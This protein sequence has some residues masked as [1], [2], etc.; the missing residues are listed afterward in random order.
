MWKP[1]SRGAM[2]VVVQ[3]PCLVFLAALVLP[4]VFS[5][6]G[7][8]QLELNDQQGWSVKSSYSSRAYDAYIVA[9]AEIEAANSEAA[10][11][12]TRTEASSNY[13]DLYWVSSRS[14]ADFLN[15]PEDLYYI[16]A[17][18]EEVI[19]QDAIQ[20]VCLLSNSTGQCVGAYSATSFLPELQ[21]DYD[22]NTFASDLLSDI[23]DTSF[24]VS[25]AFDIT[26]TDPS[27]VVMP[28]LR[29]RLQFGLPLE[30]YDSAQDRASEQSDIIQEAIQNVAIDYL[31]PLRTQNDAL[32]LYF[33]FS[34]ITNYYVDTT[35]VSD[36]VYAGAAGAFV[37]TM[38]C[39]H[40]RSVFLGFTSLLQIL[41]SFPTAYFAYR[42]IVG[43]EHFG[44]L[45][46]LAIFLV[47]GIGTDDIFIFWDAFRQSAVVFAAKADSPDVLVD[48]LDW[49]FR[50]AAGAMLVTSLTTFV[51]FFVTALSPIP[52][53]KDFGM[54]AALLIV[55]NFFMVITIFPCLVIIHM[56]YIKPIPR[57]GLV[58]TF[59]RDRWIPL[60]WRARWPIL[61]VG[62]A[63]M[64]SFGSLASRFT[65]GTKRIED[66]FDAD[67]PLTIV[68]ALKIEEFV[69]SSNAF[70]TATVTLGLELIDR[71]GTSP[72]DPSDYGTLSYSEGFAPFQTDAQQALFD[73]CSD[74]GDEN[75][76]N[77]PDYVR[78]PTVGEPSVTCWILAWRNWLESQNQT[79]PVPTEEDARNLL[80]QWFDSDDENAEEFSN[81]LVG[82]A[83]GGDNVVPNPV[84]FM[85]MTVVLA[86]PQSASLGEKMNGFESLASGLTDRF[87]DGP[88]SI[89]TGLVVS[90]YFVVFAMQEVLVRT[91][92]IGLCAGIGFGFLCLLVMTRNLR[93]SVL[94]ALN[95]LVVT[96]LV[97]GVMQL[98]L[99]E[100]GFMEAISITALV[101]LSFDFTLHFAI[102][103]VE[104]EP[105]H[106][107]LIAGVTPEDCLPGDFY[108][109]DD[110]AMVATSLLRTRV[111]F[112]RISVSVLFGAISSTTAAIAL[113]L[114]EIQYLGLFGN[115][116]LQ[117]IIFSLVAS[118]TVLPALL[119]KFGPQAPPKA[120][121]VVALQEP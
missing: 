8:T 112:T 35:I 97:L 48:R 58:E 120:T 21:A 57:L 119:M 43:I 106:A 46:S 94:A 115:F 53:I 63:L 13:L 4:L 7:V 80:E 87:R 16:R 114:C 52:N 1:T 27:L 51:A 18:E 19:A 60:V 6:I 71:A 78:T 101:G 30:G 40:T 5:A 85:T 12:P 113:T 103:Y 56:R 98:T 41:L 11:A 61:F 44:T 34:D 49:A 3:R 79:F 26:A 75:S 82:L 111:A 69:F 54:F 33:D 84:E 17:F 38:L 29:S 36:A 62:L 81:V 45:Q 99:G 102:A 117:V 25:S 55:L 42:F 95:I 76:T 9:N 91:A 109:A 20:R 100:I 50:K 37:F 22:R 65:T 59:F 10:M 24:F 89:G 88:A 83:P 73:L 39:F 92:I 70:F 121:K 72:F 104:Y 90:D 23:D 107:L 66:I 118:N 15:H 68:N 108:E 47:L 105:E 96:A 67:H 14:P 116:L 31:N 74:Y 2:S 77:R 110:G 28:M 93:V 32:I 64:V 86:V